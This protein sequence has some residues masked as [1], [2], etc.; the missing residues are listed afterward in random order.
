MRQ[1]KKDIMDTILITGAAQGIGRALAQFFAQKNYAV[2]AADILPCTF[3]EKNIVSFQADIKD[4]QQVKAVFQSIKNSVGMLHC[5]INNAGISHFQ[6][7]ITDVTAEEFDNVTAT[8]LRGAFLCAKEFVQLNQGAEYGRIINIASTRFHQNEADWDCY[9]ASK[10]GLVS[11]TSSLC[12]SLGGTGITVNAVSPGWIACTDYE[13]LSC[14]D[15][16]QHPSGRVGKPSDIARLCYFLCQRE[17]DFINGANI[18]ADG[19][20]TKR[21]IYFE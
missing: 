19:G 10:G 13:N 16:S 21:M 5:L 8:N 3:A 6:K 14:L 4:E 15:H 18:P 12:V 17:N 7:H 20:M 11:L 9:D 2:F 1:Q